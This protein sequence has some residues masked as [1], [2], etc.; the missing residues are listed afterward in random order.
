MSQY[1]P[2]DRIVTPHRTSHSANHKSLD[3]PITRPEYEAVLMAFHAL[4]FTRVGCRN[5]KATEITDLIFQE[6][7]RLNNRSALK[8]SI[9]PLSI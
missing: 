6:I 1:Y 9:R 3:R 4:G 8:Q 2:P 5:M 7:I